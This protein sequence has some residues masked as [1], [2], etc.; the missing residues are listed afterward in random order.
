MGVGE[1][2][3]RRRGTKVIESLGHLTQ[4]KFKLYEISF[5][6][7]DDKFSL[8]HKKLYRK[9][10]CLL[11]VHPMLKTILYCTYTKERK[12]KTLKLNF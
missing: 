6:V 4:V 11:K 9:D 1:S 7:M 3:L 10:S 12:K 5:I 8:L 2:L